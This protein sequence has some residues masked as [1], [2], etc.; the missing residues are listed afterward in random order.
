MSNAP[1]DPFGIFDRQPPTVIIQQ[2]P[3]AR[4]WLSVV[5]VI[6]LASFLTFVYWQRFDHQR[7][8]DKQD[9][10]QDQRDDKRDDKKD[11]DPAPRIVGKTLI[12]IHERNPQPIEHDLLL[13][14]MPAYTAKNG[15][16][17]RALDDDMTDEPVPTLLA[18]AKLKGI[19]PPCVIL[20]D[21]NDKPARV[22]AWPSDVAGLEKLK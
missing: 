6:A 3:P 18:F 9:D 1:A 19:D 7:G 10:Q 21:K 20:T 15:L 13:R 8:D 14:E 22:I 17:F 5:L 16:Q 12:F 4:D 11:P 2:Q